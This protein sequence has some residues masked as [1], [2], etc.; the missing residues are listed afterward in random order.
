ML[1]N[2][3]IP[4]LWLVKQYTLIQLFKDKLNNLIATFQIVTT[5]ILMETLL[6]KAIHLNS[7]GGIKK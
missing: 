3:L 6:L 1:I 2:L 4:L 7:K 5:S